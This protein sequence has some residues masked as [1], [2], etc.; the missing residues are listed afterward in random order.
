MKL[1][2]KK[3][4]MYLCHGFVYVRAFLSLNQAK[5]CQKLLKI[6][7]VFNLTSSICKSKFIKQKIINYDTLKS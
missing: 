6:G 5:I 2:S 1:L 3:L 4:F 7:M